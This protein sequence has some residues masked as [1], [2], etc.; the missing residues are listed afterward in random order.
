MLNP[1]L[2]QFLEEQPE[3]KTL[4]GFAWS[5][6]WRFNLVVWSLYFGIVIAI[7]ILAKLFD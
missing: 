3:G 6:I 2:K 7:L 4:V 1:N 5:L